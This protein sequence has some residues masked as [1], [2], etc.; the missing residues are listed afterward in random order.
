MKTHS[1]KSAQGNRF[2]VLLRGVNV[3]KGNRV[4]M[5]HF[6]QALEQIGYTDVVTLLNSG[7]AIFSSSS[8]SIA[9]H[10]TAIAGILNEEFEV[11][12][13]VVVK[14]AAQFQSIVANNPVQVPEADH[15]K[16]LV[17]FA[18]AD[19][20]ISELTE[21]LPQPQSTEAFKVT[22]TAAYL[23]CPNGILQSKIAAAL[24]GKAGRNVTTR[25]WATILKINARIT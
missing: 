11:S 12:T 23:Y 18:Q 16:Y 13:P 7:N 17:A 6:K 20:S 19:A 3:G 21:L 2:V 14:T 10:I 24:I 4:P 1:A 22:A 25:N 5:A 9:K 8:K 15:S